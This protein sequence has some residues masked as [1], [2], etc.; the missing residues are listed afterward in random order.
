MFRAQRLGDLRGFGA[1]VEAGGIEADGECLHA[2][3]AHLRGNSRQ[4]ARVDARREEQ[5]QGNVG[6]QSE[7][8]G[9]AQRLA[10]TADSLPALLWRR[11]GGSAWERCTPVGAAPFE[12][13]GPVRDQRRRRRQQFDAFDD[14]IGAADHP[15]REI[16][17]E[18]RRAEARWNEIGARGEERAD[19]GREE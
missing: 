18:G 8:H 16:A 7:L 13:A 11:V 2:R 4:G 5:P 3:S 14:G 12:L 19:L 1:L 10:E 17:L 15:L 6:D 9:L